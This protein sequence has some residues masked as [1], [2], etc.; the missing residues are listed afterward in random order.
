MFDIA[1]SVIWRRQ[2]GALP[3]SRAFFDSATLAADVRAPDSDDSRALRSPA[4]SHIEGTCSAEVVRTTDWLLGGEI[5]AR[6]HR[7]SHQCSG[8]TRPTMNR[9]A[10]VRS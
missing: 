1:E 2:I 6:D 10:S 3:R 4:A 5:A 8:T 7:E 9:T